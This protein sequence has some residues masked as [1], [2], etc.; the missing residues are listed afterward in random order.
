MIRRDTIAWIAAQSWCDG[1]VG[2]F[3]VSALGINAYLAAGAQ[4]PALNDVIA[5]LVAVDYDALPF[6]ADVRQARITMAAEVALQDA[7]VL[8]AIKYRPPRFQF[9]YSRRGFLRVQFSHAVVVEILT[10][11][12]GIGK[13]NA[14]V[15]AIVDVAHRSRHTTL[16]HN[17]LGF[18]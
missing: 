1:N 16:G 9:L 11:T 6:V 5:A 12:H 2:M 13:V 8:G 10:T 15:V 7:T 3:G 4:P 18:A 14:P 17:R